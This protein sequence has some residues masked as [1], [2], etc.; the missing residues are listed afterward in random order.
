MAKRSRSKRAQKI[1]ATQAAAAKYAGVS[2]RT[3]RNWMDKGLPRTKAGFV[4]SHIDSFVKKAQTRKGAKGTKAQGHKDTEG[5]VL[6]QSD[7]D[8]QRNLMRV[9]RAA[10]RD[11]VIPEIKNRRRRNRC[12]D[13]PKKFC[14]EYFGHLFYNPFTADQKKL[15]AALRE[16][17]I[18]GGLKADAEMRGG[19]KTT[20]VKIVAGVWAIVYGHIKYGLILQA[21]G[22]FAESALTDIKSCYEFNDKLAA[23]FPEICAPVRALEG[24]NQRAQTQ[25]VA[26]ERTRMIWTGNEVVFPTI[27]GAD[28]KPTPASGSVL[29]TRGMDAA[30]RGLVKGPLRPDFVGGDDLETAESAVS[31]AQTA[32]RKK[33]LTTDVLGLAGPGRRMAVIITGTIIQKDCLIDQLTDRKKNPAWRGVRKKQIIKFPTNTDLWEKYIALR[34]QDFFEQDIKSKRAHRF[35]L[36]NRKAMD[37][38]AVVSNPYNFI[39]DGGAEVSALQHCYNFVA[40]NPDGWDAFNSEFQNAPPE[41]VV[42]MARLTSESVFAKLAGTE[43]GIVPGWAEKVVGYVDVHDDKL[44][45]ALCAFRQKAVGLVFDYG[46]DRVNSPVSGTT[47]AD[48]RAKQVQVAITEALEELRLRW[49][50]GFE[51]ESGGKKF[52]NLGLVDAGYQTET[53][54]GF[55][56]SYADG[57]FRPALGS[58]SGRRGVYRSPRPGKFVRGVGGGY[59]Q[60]YLAEKRMWAYQLNADLF[61]QLA[62]NGFKAPGL[63]DAGGLSVF[64]SQIYDHEAFAE[65]LCA[66]VWNSDKQKYEVLSRNNHWLDCAAGCVA[67]GRICGIVLGPSRQ[68]P[69][70]AKQKP[71]GRKRGGYLDG[72][73]IEL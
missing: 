61:K 9:K 29:T 52:L 37:A 69:K 45:W 59:H 17:I 18:F 54:C 1:F 63:D 40:D 24:A 7:R 16:I 5:P 62:Q 60:S 68:R 26:G 27:R 42:D 65:Q 3:I 44:F 21:T 49:L 12:K 46:V 13:N 30:I 47:T 28:G 50:L 8:Y 73:S 2:P 25:T 38:G 20:I 14:R 56:K 39:A 36:R 34:K 51:S 67:A 33:I 6:S 11:I 10:E 22:P 64:G 66:E 31:R 58:H 48:R 71:P 57:T 43:R 41:T 70:K 35:Y 4:K 23:D 19:G 72:V 32:K 15:I 53:V 55:C